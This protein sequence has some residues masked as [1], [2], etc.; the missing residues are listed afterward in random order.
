MARVNGW[1]SIDACKPGRHPRFIAIGSFLFLMFYFSPLYQP[2][3]A[4]QN[5]EFSNIPSWTA[6]RGKI[7]VSRKS[8]AVK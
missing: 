2:P 1:I 8:K 5:A 6:D 4:G 3:T 7:L